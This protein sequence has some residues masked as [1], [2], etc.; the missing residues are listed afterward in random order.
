MIDPR[1]LSDLVRLFIATHERA[2]I[3]SLVLKYNSIDGLPITSIVDQILGRR[4]TREKL[5]TYFANGEV[6]YP[7]ALNLE[8]TSSETTAYFKAQLLSAV[9]TLDTM[10]DLTGG[11][12]IDSFALSKIFGAVVHVEPDGALQRLARYNHQRLGS[13]NISY[14]NQQAEHYLGTMPEVS[15]AFI[16]PSRRKDSRKVYSFRDCQPDLTRLQT[17]IFRR[18]TVLLVK[19]SPMHDIQL[20]LREIRNVQRVV[21]LAVD[22]EVRELLFLALRDFDAR[23]IISAVNITSSGTVAFDFS[24]AEEERA[25]AGYADLMPY[26]YEPNA[27]LLKA[28]AFKLIAKR[29]GVHKLHV[30]THLY[31]FDAR[32]DNFPGRIFRVISRVKGD[33]KIMGDYFPDGK[34]NVMVRNY[35]STPEELKKKLRLRDGGERYLLGFTSPSGPTLIAAERL[36]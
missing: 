36:M 15:A 3:P 35:P 25:D 18:T 12:G 22:N 17:E 33:D 26:V 10:V 7:P 9:S 29:Y 16:D 6:L 4:K 21:V 23:P 1:E 32:V 19:A 2:D 11:F 13:D 24:V 20:A 31:T 14:V 5:P 34:A 30:N 28:G 27:A 8:Q